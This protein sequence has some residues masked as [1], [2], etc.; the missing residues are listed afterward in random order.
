MTSLQRILTTLLLILNLVSVA[1]A[2]KY[3][4]VFGPEATSQMITLARCAQA[5]LERDHEV[6]L[7]AAEAFEETIRTF[8]PDN[9]PYAL[10]TF[11][12]SVNLDVF[13]NFSSTMSGFAMKGSYFQMAM[14]GS[15]RFP[16][17]LT[18]VGDD[19]LKDTSLIKRLEDHGFDLVLVHA[20]FAYPMLV[21]QRLNVKCVAITPAIPPSMHIRLFGSP[22][23]PAYSPE[24]M[25]AFTNRMTFLQRVKNT[26]FSGMQWMLAD[27]ANKGLDELKK[28][29]NI[30]PELS[31]LHSLSEAELW[32]IVSD[33][34]LDFPRPYQPNTVSVGGITAKPANP[35][36]QVGIYIH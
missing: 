17:V 13:R 11:P 24:L 15:K 33:F 4:V 20:M 32:F 22:V 16:E 10:E 3:L 19:L 8:M 2:D 25:T 23:N 21:A 5:M 28:K 1:L 18:T 9:K 36:P 30:R 7:L 34:T 12:S 27:M 26:L 6:T 31:T 29:Y 35:L 14:Y